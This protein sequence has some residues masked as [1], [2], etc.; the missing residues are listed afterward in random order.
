MPRASRHFLPGYFWHLTHRCHERSFLLTYNIDRQRWLRWL[1]EAR[2]R[3]G[4]CVLNYMITS[5]HVHLFVKDTGVGVIP[6]SM[7]LVAGRVAQEFNLRKGRGGA[8]WQDRYHATAVENNH[9]FVHAMIYI[10]LNMVRAVVVSDPCQWPFCGYYELMAQRK[11]YSII[12]RK[13]LMRAL[14]I[15]DE[16]ALVAMRRNWVDDALEE[17]APCREEKWTHSLA[18]GGHTFLE[19]IKEEL[20]SKARGRRVELDDGVAGGI[21][22]EGR[23]VYSRFSSIESGL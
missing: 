16:A 9:H 14:D 2:K 3:Y 4:F 8:F 10:D 23:S 11:R 22:K 18:V 15:N 1:F 19:T 13:E 5:N 17:G 21:I 20:G 12:D 7:Q 6:R